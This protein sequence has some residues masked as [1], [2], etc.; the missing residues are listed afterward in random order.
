MKIIL[1]FLVVV[2][3]TLH[4]VPF[5]YNKYEDQ[6]DGFTEKAIAEFKKRY[7]V[8][9]ANYLSKIPKGPLKDKKIQ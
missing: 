4:T 8:V 1:L 3:V 5:L 7:A 9:H 2:F 6:V